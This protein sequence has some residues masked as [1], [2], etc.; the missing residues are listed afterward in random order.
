MTLPILSSSELFWREY[1]LAWRFNHLTPVFIS[2]Y[3][4]LDNYYGSTSLRLMSSSSR[5][6][7]CWA[8]RVGR[9]QEENECICPVV[10]K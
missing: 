1:V 10:A 6:T 4:L 2:W 8:A 5:G 9:V 7:I 3:D